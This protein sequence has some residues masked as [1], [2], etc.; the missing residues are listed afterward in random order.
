MMAPAVEGFLD[1]YPTLRSDDGY[2]EFLETFAGALI[3]HEGSGTVVNILGFDD[4]SMSLVDVDGP[5]VEDGF[6]VFALCVY[7]ELA[8]GLLGTHEY[9]FAFEVSGARKSGVYRCFS[10][11][12]VVDL[13]LEWYA[14]DFTTWLA[15]LVEK[16][17]KYERPAG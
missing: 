17:G 8:D 12:D 7:H 2:V 3:D 5:V 16:G 13:P 10:T 6:L 11:A 9:D 14:P 4:L 15:E 1:S